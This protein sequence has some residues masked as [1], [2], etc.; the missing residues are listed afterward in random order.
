[1]WTKDQLRAIQEHGGDLIVSAAAGSGKTAVLVERVIERLTNPVRP[2]N[3]DQFLLVT[4]TKAAAAEMRN[5]LSAAISAQL[6]NNPLNAHLRRQLL[7]VHR[8]KITTVHSFC[9]SLIQEQTAALG[10]SPDFRLAD[11][12]EA[13][14]MKNE[15]LEDILE[16]LYEENQPDFIA[17]TEQLLTGR[18]DRRLA[19]VIMDTF[20]KIQSHPDPDAYLQ[21][22]ASGGEAGS[23]ANTRFGRVILDEARLAAEYGLDFLRLGV[24]QMGD[25]EEFQTTTLETFQEDIGQ[26]EALLKKIRAGDWD[27]AVEASRAVKPPRLKTPRGYPDKDLID[28]LKGMREEW[29]DS[30]KRISNRLLNVTED[31]AAVDRAMTAAALRGLAYAVQVFSTRFAAEKRRRNLLDFN[32][33]EH[34]AVALLLKDGQPTAL[35]GT[36]AQRYEEIMVDEYQDTNAVQDAI[37]G[38]LGRHNLF[39]VGDVKQSIYGFRLAD[40]YLF[41][42][43]YRKS[44]DEAV[45]DEPRRV[46]LSKNFRSRRQ[47][48]DSTNYLMK[49][50][51]RESVGDL[52]YTEREMLYLGAEYPEPDD[53]RYNT[54]ILLLDTSLGYVESEESD[55]ADDTEEA[56]K[57]DE[58][59]AAMVA[60]RIDRLLREG[61][62][63]FD[64]GRGITRPAEPGDVVI[65]MR[66]PKRKAAIYRDALAAYGLAARTEETEGLLQTA[67]VGTMV[68]LL[69]VIDNPRQ[70]I[71][72]IGTMRSPLF[73]FSEQE[74]A[75]IHLFGKSL[76]FYE[77]ACL[78][79]GQMPHVKGFLSRLSQLREFAC[80]QPVYRLLWKI[81][82]ETNALA[83][84]GAQPNGAQRQKNLLSFF[85]RARVYEAQGF[86]GLFGFNRLLRGMMDAGED[87][88]T[89]KAE[90][91]VGAVRIMSIHKSKG[92]EFPVVVLADC[93][94]SFNEQGLY[95]PILVHSELGF[96]AKVRDIERGI[97]YP[98]LE[99]QAVEARTRRESVSE[100]L[101]I[102]YVALTR[103]KEKLILTASSTRL[104]AKLEKWARFAGMERLPDYAM[105]AVR[106]PLAWI[107]TPL[108]R[109][110]AAGVLRERIRAVVPLDVN[111]PQ[112]FAFEILWPERLPERT[113]VLPAAKEA[114]EAVRLD[115]APELVY[116][117]AFLSE[118]PAKLTATGVKRTYKAEE[119]AEETLPPRREVK[120][121]RPTFAEKPLTAAERGTA[122]HL[123]L[124]FAKYEGLDTMEGV[125]RELS[126][127]RTLKILSEEQAEAVEPEKILGFFRSPLYQEGFASGKIRRE[128]KFSVIVPAAQFYEAAKSVPEET[129]LLQGVIDCLIE[130]PEGFI[131]VDFKTDR[132]T[133]GSVQARAEGYR[134]QLEAYRI[135]VET[136]FEKPVIRQVLFFLS[137]GAEIEVKTP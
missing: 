52:E 95:D 92:L 129:V 67:E 74:L 9:Q 43:K 15:V 58:A 131:V 134:E 49:A 116:P 65:L 17:L 41:L 8:A 135:A 39:M 12:Q 31:E 64:R 35:A 24:Q 97:Q 45:A 72:L 87:F 30:A 103:A 66:S 121:R 47:V 100:E 125:E 112:V 5:K 122:H 57:K 91:S 113:D 59:E 130:T 76:P 110:P 36:V 68:S 46:V 40:P 105:G 33:L 3:I 51:M 117:A 10:L 77:A 137:I 108:L 107:L 80:D 62:P 133:K 37:F 98:S 128:F 102:L 61:L 124:Q 75:E 2:V 132:V 13:I 4:F 11:D 38:A 126:R 70:D 22:M 101:R 53:P 73:G 1:M 86:R 81:Y 93:A 6:E 115:A 120:L 26:A 20:Q 34:F 29:K 16:E 88:K 55:A 118:L 42:E 99:R 44:V 119:A 14:L 23:P 106:E 96:G 82:D 50:I 94:K 85:E 56:P 114:A 127:L 123:F 83:I 28:E 21:R 89:V 54:E 18:D 25:E 60:A 7:L 48:L 78:A 32:D 136:V 71:D 90:S 111:A 79:A 63:I 19:N 69:A 109:H 27:G 104:N 84:Y